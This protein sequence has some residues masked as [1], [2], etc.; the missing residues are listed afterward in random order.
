M[1]KLHLVIALFIVCDTAT[2]QIQPQSKAAQEQIAVIFD[3]DGVLFE[4]N[5]RAA[6]WNLGPINVIS[7]LLHHRSIKNMYKK[8]YETMDLIQNSHDKLSYVAKDHNGETLP[9]L[10]N[11]WLLGVRSNSQLFSL[12]HDEIKGHPDWFSTEQEQQICARITQFMFNPHS[13]T[14]AYRPIKE[15]VAFAKQC[16]S[17]QYQ[18]YILSNWNGEAFDLLMAQYPEIFC[19]FDGIVISGHVH[20]IKP[21]P[22]MFSL[23]TKKIPEYYYVFIDDLPENIEVA[24]SLGIQGILAT[25]KHPL[26]NR[27]PNVQKIQKEFAQIEQRILKHSSNLFYA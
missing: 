6:L 16:K 18:L 26:L 15:M 1:Q 13:F 14:H 9:Y 2:F 17:K 19:L 7:Y 11:E 4:T 10:I 20:K 25:P 22:T 3:L 21:D 27:A 8:L 5:K 12:I 23:I 24:R